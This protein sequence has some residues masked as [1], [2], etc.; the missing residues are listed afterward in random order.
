MKAKQA[1]ALAAALFL[2]IHSHPALAHPGISLAIAKG[3][4]L[5][6][7]GAIVIRIHVLCGPFAGSEDFQEAA[8]GAAQV[9]SGAEAEGGIDGPVICDGHERTRTAT[10]S[11][12]TDAGFEPGQAHANV[13]LSVCRLVDDEQICFQ[14]ATQRTVAV[15]EQVVSGN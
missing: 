6:E 3:A 9:Q 7:Q 14:G 5:T 2:T 13:A 8:A 11:S 15:Q 1:L 4:Q 12:F 10:L